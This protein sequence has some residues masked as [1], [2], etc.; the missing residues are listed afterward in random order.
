M[1]NRN[2]CCQRQNQIIEPTINKCVEKDFY[3]EVSHIIPVHTH[4][5][6]RHIYNH[7]YT[8]QYSCSEENQIINNECNKCNGFINR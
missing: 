6:N 2:N 3:H 8:P 4:F 1:F 5:I 7:T